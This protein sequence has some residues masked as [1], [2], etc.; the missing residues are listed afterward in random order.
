MSVLE[1]FLADTHDRHPGV[2]S[3]AMACLPVRMAGAS[4][5]STYALLAGA[6][7]GGP[8]PLAVLDLACG[9]GAL[10]SLLAARDQPGLTLHGLDFSA[11]ELAAAARRLG[12]RARLVRSR[13]QRLPYAEASF[14]LVLSHMAL[15][16][17]E[18][19][20]QVLAELRR[21]LR[22][23]GVVAA[24]V[25]APAPASAVQQVF[26][27]TLRSSEAGASW[28]G[29]RFPGRAWRDEDGIRRLWGGFADL[30]I[31]EVVA[32]LP[33]DPETAWAWY[34]GVYELLMMSPP[35]RARFERRFRAAVASLAADGRAAA[36]PLH[37]RRVTARRA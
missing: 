28:P 22:P 13:A 34:G 17:M 10:L 36:L 30:C 25:A 5:A 27:D 15:M 3:D 11:G 8:A 6:V 23:G 31:D 32:E 2:T 1:R 19:V 29:L 33:C 37:F 7:P 20:D 26:I 4:H 12:G 14:D 18:D 16:L 9:D 24:L 35:E 21:V